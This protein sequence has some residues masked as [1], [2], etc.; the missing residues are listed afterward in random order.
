ML[1]LLAPGYTFARKWSKTKNYQLAYRARNILTPQPDSVNYKF[2]GVR[3]RLTELAVEIG[4]N[5]IFKKFNKD[6]GKNKN[7]EKKNRVDPI[8]S[9]LVMPEMDR[10]F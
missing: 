6:K 4:V 2:V 9:Q 1:S 7:M 5:S 8:F 10:C 3:K